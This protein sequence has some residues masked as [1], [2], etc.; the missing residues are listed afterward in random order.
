MAT[1]VHNAL[2]FLA[3]LRCRRQRIGSLVLLGWV[4]LGQAL[5]VVHRI[6]HSRVEHGV[7]CTLCVAAD[8]S[9]APSHQAVVALR[10]QEPDSVATSATRPPAALVILSYQS[11]A[12]PPEHRRA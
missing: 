11:R 4:L 1:P 2:S 5:L 3:R 10:V 9:T 8:H 12:P 6:D 7:T